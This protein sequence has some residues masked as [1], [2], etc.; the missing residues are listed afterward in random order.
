MG[1]GDRVH[2]HTADMTALPFEEASFDVVTSSLAI[3]NIE[4]PVARARALDEITR[5]LRPGG[6]LVLVDLRHAT[7]YAEHLG[8]HGWHSVD[9]HGLGPRFWFGGPW[10]SA[11]VVTAIRS[12]D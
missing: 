4:D 1:V 5:V 9:R 6:R 8:K 10:Q 7:S 2:L 11:S 12:S 3:H